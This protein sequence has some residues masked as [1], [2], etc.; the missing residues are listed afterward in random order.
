MNQ[1]VADEKARRYRQT[2]TKVAAIQTDAQ[3]SVVPELYPDWVKSDWRDLVL[4][5]KRRHNGK[6]WKFRQAKLNDESQNRE[7]GSA[8]SEALWIEVSYKNGVKVIPF[9]RRALNA[10]EKFMKG[11]LG[12]WEG[13]AQ[14]KRGVW[15]APADTT[16]WGPGTTGVTWTFVRDEA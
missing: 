1:Q 15:S 6:L 13:D 14:A 9:P 16:V 8:G 4:D 5:S 3:A 11:E 2:M 12:W 10:D 7:P